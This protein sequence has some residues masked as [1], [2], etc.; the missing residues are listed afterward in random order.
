MVSTEKYAKKRPVK[1]I[2]FT[3]HLIYS[4]IKYNQQISPKNQKSS[5]VTTSK[6]SLMMTSKIH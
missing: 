4:P 1:L 5:E 3:I 6:T 2:T